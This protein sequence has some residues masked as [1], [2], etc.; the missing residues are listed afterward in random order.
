[1]P[2]FSFG[3]KAKPKDGDEYSLGSTE[4]FQWHAES[5]ENSIQG[6]DWIRSKAV[7]YLEGAYLVYRDQVFQI[8]DLRR[9]PVRVIVRASSQ[10]QGGIAG[11]TGSGEL[12][13]CAGQWDA[14]QYCYGIISHELCNLFT[15]E[16]VTPGWPTAWWANHRS[17]FP[18]VIANEVMHSAV[19]RFYRMWGDYN[20]PLVVMFE[21]MYKTYPGMFPRMFRKMQELRISLEGLLDPLLSQTVYYFMFYGAQRALGR[22]FVSP[23][24]PLI[25]IRVM[26]NLESKYHLGVL[27]LP[28]E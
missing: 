18:T 4:H 8:G 19:P 16:C 25:D 21:R 11:A 7:S 5:G 9:L 14:N 22:Y 3:R 12:S 2:F 6:S 24:M 28:S 26:S 13:Y 10:C 23:P 15:G 17:P 27:S 20:D 1:M